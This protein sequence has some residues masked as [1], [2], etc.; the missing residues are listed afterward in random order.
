MRFAKRRPAVEGAA[1]HDDDGRAADLDRGRR[2]RAAQLVAYAT[3][4]VPA[5]GRV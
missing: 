2:V 4:Y 1:A 3:S 5:H